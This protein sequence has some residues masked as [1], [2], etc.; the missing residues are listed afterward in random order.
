ML[1]MSVRLYCVIHFLS[2]LLGKVC[3]FDKKEWLS[4]GNFW[5]SECLKLISASERI[6]E[7][8]GDG[9]N[10]KNNIWRSSAA[11][12]GHCFSFFS[13]CTLSSPGLRWMRSGIS[14]SLDLFS[15]VI[16]TWL[17]YFISYK[18]CV[19]KDVPVFSDLT[20]SWNVFS[21]HHPVSGVATSTW[22][23]WAADNR[24]VCSGQRNVCSVCVCVSVKERYL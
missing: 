6:N 12:H 23:T 18:W 2:V 13:W 24:C 11:G 5:T 22:D 15:V 8:E 10:E 7:I 4:A 17:Y 21:I 9:T 1:S 19:D 16:Q 14:W 3:G 20:P